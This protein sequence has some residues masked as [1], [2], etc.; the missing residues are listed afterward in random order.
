MHIKR[1]ALYSR[2]ESYVSLHL[3]SKQKCT[4][5]VSVSKLNSQASSPINEGWKPPH[6]FDSKTEDGTS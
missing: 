5:L 6:L 1:T 4:R 3:T 2:A